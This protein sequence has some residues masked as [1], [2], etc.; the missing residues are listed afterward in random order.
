MFFFSRKI[1]IQFFPVFYGKWDRNE[2][3]QKNLNTQYQIEKEEKQLQT[4]SVSS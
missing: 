2:K 1:V 3:Q 4:D